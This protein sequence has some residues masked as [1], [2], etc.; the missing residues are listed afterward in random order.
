MKHLS[1]STTP[2][3]A[4][5]NSVI[6]SASNPHFNQTWE[7]GEFY[8][9]M[10]GIH[11]IR[12]LAMEGEK[13]IAMLQAFEWK[14][15]PLSLGITSG[16]AGEGGGPVF[17]KT[18]DRDTEIRCYQSLIATLFR[19]FKEKKSLRFLLYTFPGDELPAPDI[20]A[21]TGIKSTPILRLQ[22]SEELFL[23]SLGHEGRWEQTIGIKR[24]L[25]IMEGGRHDLQEYCEIQHAVALAKK[26]NTKH[27]NTLREWEKLWDICSKKP[28]TIRFYIG[29]KD[30]KMVGALIVLYYGDTFFLRGAVSNPEGKK[31]L[32]NNALYGRAIID[33]IRDG[34]VFC[35]MTG[36]TRDTHDP[37]YGITAFKLSFRSELVDFRRYSAIGNRYINYAVEKIRRLFGYN[38]WFPLPIYP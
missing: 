13:P 32:V 22:E 11:P 14:K 16:G 2:T 33:G 12:L 7:W 28:G 4:Q 5:W 37:I 1:L 34:Y 8:G 9:M 29:K 30:E 6:R 27:M 26:L 18:I 31:L 10:P 23:Q 15:G 35:N 17:V 20:S 19:I 3:E 38:L 25:K 21:K 24:G 36:G